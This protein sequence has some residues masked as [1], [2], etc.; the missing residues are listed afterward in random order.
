MREKIII[1]MYLA[2]LCLSAI[3]L[4]NTPWARAP[5]PAGWDVVLTATLDTY[6]DVSKF[7]V[8]I[9]ATECF[10]E[11]YDAIEPPPPPIITLVSYFWHPNCPSEPADERKL[12]NST[13]PP[14]ECALAWTYKVQVGPEGTLNISWSASDIANIPSE[15]SVFLNGVNMRETTEHCFGAEADTTYT[16]T[17]RVT[18][19]YELTVRAVGVGTTN[20]LPGTYPYDC[21]MNISVAA[22]ETD[23][24]FDHWDLDGVYYSTSPSVGVHIDDHHTLTAVFAGGPPQVTFEEDEKGMTIEVKFSG[25]Q[26]SIFGDNSF[27]VLTIPGCGST[28]EKGK[29]KLPKYGITVA[30]PFN[31]DLEIYVVETESTTLEGYQVFPVQEE[32]PDIDEIYPP[33]PTPPFYVDEE[34]YSE[35]DDLYPTTIVE[36]EATGMLRD[37]RVL[38]LRFLAFQHNPVQGILEFYSSI[39]LRID[40]FEYQMT[41]SS[42]TLRRHSPY[43]EGLY[44]TLLG[45]NQLKNAEEVAE[46]ENAADPTGWDFIIVTDSS[47]LS[48]A[49]RL[50]TRRDAEGLST[51]VVAVQDIPGTGTAEDIKAHI[52]NAYDTWDPRPSYLLLLGDA[53]LIPTFYRTVHPWACSYYGCGFHIGTD[54]YYAIMNGP[55]VTPPYYDE[56]WTPDIFH[57]RIPVDT[58]AQADLVIDK[59][60]EYEDNQWILGEDTAVV[61]GY[62]QD[63][64]DNGYEDRRFSLTL[65]EIRNFLLGEGW[66][67]ERLYTTEPTVTPTN[68]NNGNYDAG[69]PLPADL[70]RPTYPWD[71]DTADVTNAINDGRFFVFHRDHGGSRNRATSGVEGW[72]DPHYDATDVTALSNSD[73]YTV[74]FTINC[75]TGWF[76]GETDGYA[77]RSHESLCEAFLR[78]SDGGAVGAFGATRISSSGWND[79]LAKGF[80]DAIWPNFDTTHGGTTPLLR[81][82]E[83]LNYGKWYMYT[84]DGWSAT[85][86]DN[87]LMTFEMFHYFGDPTMEFKI[88]TLAQGN[89]TINVE[90]TGSTDPSPGIHTY[91]ICTEVTVDA[92]ETDPCWEFDHWMLDG[93]D[94]GSS[95]PYT[96]H[97]DQDHTLTAVFVKSQFTLTIEVSGTGTTAPPPGTYILECCT[98]VTVDAVWTDPCWSFDHWDLDGSFLSYHPTITIHIDDDHTLTAVFTPGWN[99]LIAA[100]KEDYIDI[101]DFGMRCDATDCFDEAYDEVDPPAPPIGVISYFW[102]PCCPSTPVDQRKLATS[103]I[104]LAPIMT[105][106]YKVKPV[107]IDGTMCILWNLNDIVRV[108]PELAVYLHCPDGCVVNMRMQAGYCFEAEADTTYT[109]TIGVGGCV[110]ELQLSAGWNMVSFPCL[111][112]DPS[113][114]NILGCVDYYQVVTWDGT[115]YVS[116]ST[117]EAGQGYWVLVLADTTVTVANGVPVESYERRFCG[118]TMIGSIICTVDADCVFPDYYRLYTWDGTKYV[119]ATLIEPGKGYWALVL[120]C[121]S[122]IVD[123]SCCI[124]P[125]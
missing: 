74:V 55:E 29:P 22:V 121:T 94:V 40:Y 123:D 6:Q 14:S 61:A 25:F 33:F 50:A 92:L 108:P 70:L 57:G 89:L 34:F 104:G 99:V 87:R 18:C 72:G 11:A 93:V 49:N 26:R 124:P 41:K 24:P 15:C 47:L 19:K 103:K 64:N 107:A 23:G 105:W 39:T 21:C 35:F 59:I 16:F 17:I 3:S 31:V 20:P 116:P 88:P 28:G 8:R 45:Y 60:F 81:M 115:C 2:V 67:I 65:E 98:D 53:E 111:P 58:L 79:D 73:H 84:I 77:A 42:Q 51:H 106:T 7:G 38:P 102:H 13:I 117:A 118:W 86:G 30:V 69:V 44:S 68:Y 5:V 54:L 122:I 71:A 46:P 27:D 48:A 75:E 125:P 95:D 80:V 63:D 120:T 62:F 101:S 91:D 110:F 90:G 113:F 1:A 43:F 76:D 32:A 82:G 85:L 112:E 78:E 100:M 119:Q 56:W 114:N 66:N 37:V 9:D 10:D 36:Y 12:T 52:Q 97:M 96:L 83:I 4:Y 109:F